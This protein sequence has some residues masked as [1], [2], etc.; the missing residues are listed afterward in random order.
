MRA[1]LLAVLL[2]I[3]SAACAPEGWRDEHGNPT[4]ATDARK[5]VRGFSGW[6]LVTPD[7]NWKAKWETPSNTVPRFD[8]AKDVS[9]GGRAWV[10]ILFG[11]PQPNGAGD[12]DV[13]CDIDV[14]K[15]DGT[16]SVHQADAVCF[17]GALKSPPHFAF[18]SAPV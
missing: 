16:T 1:R 18:L 5:S 7:S 10:L 14:V 3:S 2:L 6:V 17:R 8:E 15:P 13:T 11:N 9:R 12:V 4:P